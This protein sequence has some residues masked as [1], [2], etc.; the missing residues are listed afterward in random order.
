MFQGEG[1]ALMAKQRKLVGIARCLT[2]TL[3]VPLTVKMRTGIVDGKNT[4]HSLIP[5]LRE[6]GVSVV[7]VSRCPLMYTVVLNFDWDAVCGSHILS[8]FD[9]KSNLTSLTSY[10][11]VS[12]VGSVSDSGD[13]KG[14]MF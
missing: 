13:G 9:W 7:T 1:C 5:Q 14:E 4:A 2:S 8:V 12:L 3:D 6:A 11:G 10:S